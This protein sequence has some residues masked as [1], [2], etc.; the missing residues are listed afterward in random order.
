MNLDETKHNAAKDSQGVIELRLTDVKQLFNSLDP[1]PFHERDLDSDAEE[2]IVSWARELPRRAPLVLLV[3]LSDPPPEGDP[4]TLIETGVRAYFRYRKQLITRQLRQ[5][6][7]RGRVSLVIGILFL[8]ACLFL[9]DK[10]ALLGDGALWQITREGLIIGGWVAMWRPIELI[11]YDWWPL[12]ID[13]RVY[14]R[15]S[16]VDV[17]VILRE[18]E[19]PSRQQE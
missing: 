13:R 15:L 1:A 12:H 7:N 16:Q 18:G 6:L 4:A 14:H 5:M 2:F 10:V 11:L 17:R 9:A 8:A 3:F 19:P